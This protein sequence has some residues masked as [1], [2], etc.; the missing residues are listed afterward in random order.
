LKFPSREWLYFD[1]EQRAAKHE[2]TKREGFGFDALVRL[3]R[4]GVAL[5][6]AVTLLAAGNALIAQSTVQGTSVTSITD[7]RMPAAEVKSATPYLPDAPTPIR[8]HEGGDLQIFPK[9]YLVP[10][11]AAPAT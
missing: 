1:L 8:L 5:A 3:N 9:A 6:L 4:L 11:H 7:Q 10:L 2:Q